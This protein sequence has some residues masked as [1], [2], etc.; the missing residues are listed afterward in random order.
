MPGGAPVLRLKGT[1][2]AH[3]VDQVVGGMDTIER[4]DQPPGLQQVAGHHL[5]PG[6]HL[7]LEEL[8][9][10]RQAA[11][12][13]AGAADLPFQ[14]HHQ[15]DCVRA[16]SSLSLHPAQGCAAE[17]REHG[18]NGRRPDRSGVSPRPDEAS[19]SARHG[20]PAHAKT[21]Y[22]RGCFLVLRAHPGP[23]QPALVHPGQAHGDGLCH[24]HRDGLG[25]KMVRGGPPSRRKPGP[26]PASQQ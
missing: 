13:P 23:G 4:L 21:R 15:P 22:S 26:G 11:Y 20:R 2:G 7:R 8:G 18:G 9:T 6:P 14:H 25:Q 3:G 10:T 16:N 24:V 12:P 5:G 19:G 17:L 1:G